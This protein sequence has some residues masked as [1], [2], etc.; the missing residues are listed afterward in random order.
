M[1][2]WNRRRFGIVSVLAYAALS[3]AARFDM[4]LGEQIASLVYPLDTFSMY[5]GPPADTIGHLLVRDAVGEIHRVRDFAAYHCDAELKRGATR[6][7]DQPGF[8]YH[9]D[10]LVRYVDGHSGSGATPVDLIYRTWRLQPS[11]PPSVE[12][13]CLI[14]HCMVAP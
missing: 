2:I 8:A 4:S 10:D 14:A 13:D 5:A 9:Y 12:A 6:C 3:W 11:E 1:T 7:A